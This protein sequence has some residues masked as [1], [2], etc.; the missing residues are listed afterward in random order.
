MA[1]NGRS[2]EAK[3]AASGK[4]G[5]K[6]SFLRESD[7][8]HA[9][10]EKMVV[11]FQPG[12]AVDQAKAKAEAEAKAKAEAEANA[13][14]SGASADARSGSTAAGRPGLRVVG[15]RGVSVVICLDLAR[16]DG[17]GYCSCREIV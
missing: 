7:P 12:G 4:G 6:F 15:G 3:I 8:Y 11:D 5:A 1:R 10:Y 17:D 14:A 9:Y 2:F 16:S 13:A